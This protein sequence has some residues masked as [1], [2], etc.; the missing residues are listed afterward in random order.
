MRLKVPGVKWAVCIPCADWSKTS[1]E[2][3]IF[4]MP[5][6]R[7]K[8]GHGDSANGQFRVTALEGSLDSQPKCEEVGQVPLC[9]HKARPLSQRKSECTLQ[10]TPSIVRPPTQAIDL[11]WDP[12]REFGMHESIWGPLLR[13]QRALVAMARV[14]SHDII[15]ARSRILL[16]LKGVAI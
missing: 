2:L 9:M 14:L 15:T 12:P 16:S 8:P 1:S 4:S 11:A 7:E 5:E 10:Q 13:V 3:G 6:R